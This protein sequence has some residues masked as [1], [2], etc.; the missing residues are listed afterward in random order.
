ML[1]PVAKFRAGVLFAALAGL[2]VAPAAMAE[3]MVKVV[4][5]RFTA[6]PTT[7]QCEAAIGIACYNA[8]QFEHAYGTDQLYP[9]GV[10][11]AGQTIVIVDSFGSPTVKQDLQSYD[12]ANGLPKP[13]SFKI[14]APA[15]TIPKYNPNDPNMGGWAFETTLDVDMAHTMAP[16]ANILLVETP[17]AE[18]TGVTGFPQMMDAEQYVIDH[19]MGNVISQSFAAAEQTFSDPSQILGLRYA[20]EDAQSHNVTVVSATG[21]QG[22]TSA[23][24]DQVDYYPYNVA[25]WPASDPLVTAVGG[26]QLNLDAS[27]NRTAPDN[28]WNDT[29]LFGSPAAGGGGVSTVF[30]RPSYQD[31]V[32]GVV[33]DMRGEPDISASAAVNGGANIYIGFTNPAYGITSPGWYIVGGTS[34]ATPLTAGIVSLADQVAG[35]GLGQINPTLYQLE[36]AA[37]PGITDITAGNNGVSFTN[38]GGSDDGSY[39]LPGFAAGTGYDLASG[40][41]TPSAPQFVYELA[42]GS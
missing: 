35:H 37:S 6:P 26:T 15:G 1:T 41:G 3:P 7:A 27:G 5:K 21:D 29:A 28:V 22:P 10:T 18:T 40:V 34:E 12:R 39:T 42:D 4:H 24:P 13:P 11:G 9:R 16:G 30:G 38:T 32:S 14:I 2:V 19:H 25:N 23:E 8:A 17:V 36:S 33:G 31:S 20:Y